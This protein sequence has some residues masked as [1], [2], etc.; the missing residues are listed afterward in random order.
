MFDSANDFNNR[1]LKNTAICPDLT[2]I[3][4]LLSS[5]AQASPPELARL[6]IRAYPPLSLRR[7]T[8]KLVVHSIFR[9]PLRNSFGLSS[10]LPSVSLT[11][12]L[13]IQ[14]LTDTH[15]IL[16]YNI[17]I[18]FLFLNWQWRRFFNRRVHTRSL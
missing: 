8:I 18:T 17:L 11:S 13:A 9:R 6:S 15:N 3:Y 1:G 4:P 2:Q 16:I 10:V 7:R 5:L 14:S 12:T